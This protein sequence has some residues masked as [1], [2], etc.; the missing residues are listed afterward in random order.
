LFVI[1][2]GGFLKSFDSAVRLFKIPT[3][4]ADAY[5]PYIVHVA[6]SSIL[7]MFLVNVFFLSFS[8]LMTG[9]F[10]NPALIS[11]LEESSSPE[12]VFE[13][14]LF[15][16][17]TI[18]PNLITVFILFVVAV[19]VAYSWIDAMYVYFVSG[20]YSK[21]KSL[22]EDS[23]RKAASAAPTVF[24][25]NMVVTGLVFLITLFLTLLFFV[26]LFLNPSGFAG[27][28]LTAPGVVSMAVSLL[29][30]IFTLAVVLFLMSPFFMLVVPVVVF[31]KKGVFESVK[32]SF[33]HGRKNYFSFLAFNVIYMLAVMLVGIAM[34]VLYYII[35]IP[36]VGPILFAVF[37]I[38][39]EAYLF[40]VAGS[41]PTVLYLDYVKRSKP[42]L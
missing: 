17:S 9:L 2:R 42:P 34:S 30:W 25:A 28:L 7:F 27:Y 41:M 15:F 22:I 31:E 16:L 37:T 18:I 6:V 36:L 40:A 5:Y 10:A 39:F 13:S 3:R 32:R 14:M 38:V 21:K 8:S 23:A 29:A 12:Q 1:A 24:F 26:H 19:F 33:S 35:L 11:A 4:F 20:V